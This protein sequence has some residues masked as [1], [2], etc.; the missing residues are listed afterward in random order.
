M[1]VKKLT[2][3]NS[4][5]SSSKAVAVAGVSGAESHPL[6][7]DSR[8]PMKP[9]FIAQIKG[10]KVLLI[11]EPTQPRQNGSGASGFAPPLSGQSKLEQCLRY[12]SAAVSQ[13]RA[14]KGFGPATSGPF[15]GIKIE[16]PQVPI[17]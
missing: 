16:S 1:T 17:L 12:G 4:G 15:P 2:G 7:P 3:Q 11:P 8:R 13:Q 9:A 10:K 5:S 14:A 6:A